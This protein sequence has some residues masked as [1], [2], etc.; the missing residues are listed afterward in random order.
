MKF[1]QFFGLISH[2]IFQQKNLRTSTA[3]PV[4]A[5][6]KFSEFKGIIQGKCAA[7]YHRRSYYFTLLYVCFL[8]SKSDHVQLLS[9]HFHSFQFSKEYVLLIFYLWRVFLNS[10]R[11]KQNFL[12]YFWS[13]FSHVN[14]WNLEAKLLKWQ[15]IHRMKI[16]FFLVI[17]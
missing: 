6:N 13:L 1:S 7:I 9:I 17:L 16:S 10:C 15:T 12:T 5:D 2:E 11:L 4:S 3:I 8:C 14:E